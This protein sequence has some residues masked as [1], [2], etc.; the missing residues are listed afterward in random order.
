[1]TLI[2]ELI[3][4]PLMHFLLH[5]NKLHP[6]A[7][8]STGL[9]F[10]I[11]WLFNAVWTI[12]MV[13]PYFTEHYE[14]NTYERLV[15]GSAAICVLIDLCYLIYVVCACVAVSRW[16][17]ARKDAA[18]YR[19]GLHDGIELAGGVARENGDTVVHDEEPSER[20]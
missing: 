3:H 15:Q 19:K 13:D 14:I 20:V 10:A 12:L 1:M 2:P 5:K 9:I 18:A 11:L 4:L 8:L 16:R 17:K 7:A 6:V